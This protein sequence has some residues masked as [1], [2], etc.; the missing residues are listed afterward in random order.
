[1]RFARIHCRP[2][3]TVETFERVDDPDVDDIRLRRDA[4]EL[5]TGGGA[6][7]G[8]E[9]RDVRAVAAQIPERGR[10]D[11]RRRAR[12]VDGGDDAAGEIRMRGD[13]AVHDRD[14]DPVTGH[15]VRRPRRRRAG[16]DDTRRLREPQTVRDVSLRL[17]RVVP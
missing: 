11:R 8:R 1:M 15:P 16:L 17:Q 2:R 12:E 10:G 4:G 13:A 9:A 5:A 14:A 7:A 3:R 6:V